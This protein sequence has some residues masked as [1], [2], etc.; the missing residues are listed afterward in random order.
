MCHL[1]EFV[2]PATGLQNGKFH[3]QTDQYDQHGR[4]FLN[5]GECPKI[6][7]ARS[8][9]M[10]KVPQQH[11]RYCSYHLQMHCKLCPISWCY[12]VCCADGVRAN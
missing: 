3:L 1:E 6:L 7:T 8:A 9:G 10:D 2:E 11:Q 4:T 5:N 12:L